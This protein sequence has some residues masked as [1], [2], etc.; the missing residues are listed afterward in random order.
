MLTAQRARRVFGLTF[1]EAPGVMEGFTQCTRCESVVP[2]RISREDLN[3][4]VQLAN[5]R[6]STCWNFLRAWIIECR[7]LLNYIRQTVSHRRAG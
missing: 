7:D 3:S 5:M 6:V 2:I 1:N 4:H